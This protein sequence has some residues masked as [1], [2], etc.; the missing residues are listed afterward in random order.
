MATSAYTQYLG[1]PATGHLG[2]IE[3]VGAT[4]PGLI[5]DGTL[6]IVGF[7]QLRTKRALR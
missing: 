6:E 2:A 1:V 5:E 3:V 4:E 7:R